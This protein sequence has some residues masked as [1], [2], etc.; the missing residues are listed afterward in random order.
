M[1]QHAISSVR[2]L[3]VAQSCL[4]LSPSLMAGL[5]VNNLRRHLPLFL[6]TS[7]LLAG[8]ASAQGASREIYLERERAA[9]RLR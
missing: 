4:L 2:C 5:Q 9:G 6:D 8:S 3:H 1:A 7:V